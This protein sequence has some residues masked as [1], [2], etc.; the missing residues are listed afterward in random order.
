MEILQS[1]T[2]PL[3]QLTYVN[4]IVPGPHWVIETHWPVCC[5]CS[6][7]S[8]SGTDLPIWLYLWMS[9][10]Q[11]RLTGMQLPALISPTCSLDWMK[12]KDGFILVP[13]I[14]CLVCICILVET[15]MVATISVFTTESIIPLCRR[16]Y[17]WFKN[18]C[19]Y[20]Y[21]NESFSTHV[22]IG[23]QSRHVMVTVNVIC[24]FVILYG[25]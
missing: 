14:H 2:K 5:T 18:T 7:G 1:Y 16:R 8:P 23:W 21:W 12:A 6:L 24:S 9:F 25:E 3:A 4:E 22:G 10:S 19:S 17:I 15:R 13:Q 20:S 11:G